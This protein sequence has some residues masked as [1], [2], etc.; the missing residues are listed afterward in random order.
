[1]S[2]I[3]K[4]MEENSDLYVAVN[5]LLRSAIKHNDNTALHEFTQMRLSSKTPP[6]EFPIEKIE[7]LF[8]R[9]IPLAN[10]KDFQRHTRAVLDTTNNKLNEIIDYLKE[11]HEKS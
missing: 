11:R 10:R 2:N 9:V 8:S 7:G 5:I 6:K 1:M 4:L 3:D